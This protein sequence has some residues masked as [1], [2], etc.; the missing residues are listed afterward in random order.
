MWG[1]NPECRECLAQREYDFQ[2]RVP[3][4]CCDL[5][6]ARYAKSK[7]GG[8]NDKARASGRVQNISILNLELIAKGFGPIW[9]QQL[10]RKLSMYE[11]DL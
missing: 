2:Q 5:N 3:M 6:Y 9:F 8:S 1:L 4:L 11:F 7:R 10:E